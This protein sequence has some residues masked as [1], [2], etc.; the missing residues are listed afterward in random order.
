MM[1]LFDF[2]RIKRELGMDSEDIRQLMTIYQAELH[3]DFHGLNEEFDDRNWSLLKNRL[4]KMK[5]DA[6]NMCLTPIY[7]A[8]AEMEKNLITNDFDALT[9][10]LNSVKLLENQFTEAFEHY[11]DAEENM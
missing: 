8:F 6:A 2:S 5:G 4:H 10:H 9:S 11:L 1:D 3:K 7:D